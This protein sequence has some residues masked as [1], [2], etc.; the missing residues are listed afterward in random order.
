MV[1]R[2]IE[3]EKEEKE[4]GKQSKLDLSRVASMLGEPLWAPVVLCAGAVR[5][6][7]WQLQPDWHAT[8]CRQ[9]FCRHHTRR[10]IQLPLQHAHCLRAELAQRGL[11][12]ILVVLGRL[13]VDIVPRL[14]QGRVHINSPALHIQDRVS[15][16][17]GKRGMR[18]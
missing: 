8:E 1:S 10:E 14:Q 5:M 16:S 18:S 11:A 12:A 7:R 6:R 3:K 2:E 17:G 15:R 13:T 4:R 9:R